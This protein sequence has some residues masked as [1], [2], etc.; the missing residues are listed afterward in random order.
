MFVR[1]RTAATTPPRLNARARL[2]LTISTTPATIIGSTISTCTTDWLCPWADRADMYTQVTGSMSA[3]V[4]SR[5]KAV[6]KPNV[7]RATRSAGGA[8]DW[9]AETLSRNSAAGAF[10]RCCRRSPVSK[11]SR[12]GKKWNTTRPAIARSA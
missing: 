1:N 10:A 2:L 7:A 8:C 5:M 6:L 11:P 3:S 12:A 9:A 4:L